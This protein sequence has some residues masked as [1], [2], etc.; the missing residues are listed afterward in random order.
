MK[1]F[2]LNF[3]KNILK[4]NVLVLGAFILLFFQGMGAYAQI[5]TTTPATRCGEGSVVLHATATSGTIKWYAEPFY[6]TALGTGDTFTTPS[7]TVT[8]TYYVDAVDGNGCSVNTDRGYLRVG[9]TATISENAI[10][11]AIFYSSSTF[12]QSSTT[13]ET[14]TLTGTS[15]GTFSV[16]PST[17]LSLTSTGSFTPSAC[18]VGTYTIT[19]T[20]PPTTGCVEEPATTTVSIVE[21]PAPPA[22]SYTGSP[23]C[24]T[25]SDKTVTQTGATGGTYSA[26]PSGLVINSTTGTIS[27]NGS[28]GGTYTVIY[29]VPGAGGCDPQTDNVSV[30]IQQR[31]TATISYNTPFTKNQGIQSV[32]LNGTGDYTG[33]TYSYTASTSGTLQL[34]PGTGAIDPGSSDAGT[35]TIYYTI[36]A[37]SPCAGVTAQTTVTIYQMATATISGETAA[38]Q[39]SSPEPEITFTGANGVAP[40]TFTYKINSGYSQT[41]STTSESSQAVV[42]QPTLVAGIY[43]YTLLSVTDN[44]GSTQLFSESNTATITVS[45]PAVATFEYTDSPYCSDGENPGPTFLNGGVAGTFSATP[46]TLIF[47]SGDGVLPGT[48]DLEASTP[49]TYTVTNT[50]A[51]AGGCDIITATAEVTITKLPLAGFSYPATIYCQ[52][53]ETPPT[54]TFDDGAVAGTFTSVPAGV[55][56]DATT[57]GKIDLA[58]STP[59]TYTILNTISASGGCSDVVARVENFQIIET[60][61]SPTIYYS[62]SPYC[63]TITEA[64]PVELTGSTGGTFTFNRTSEG[65]G[66]LSISET[67]G[68]ITP[69][70]SAPGTYRITYTVGV[71]SCTTTAGTDVTIYE[72]PVVTNNSTYAICSGENTNITL[73]AS[74]TSSF[75]WTLGEVSPNILDASA[76]SGGNIDQL[77]S[78]TSYTESGT[79]EYVVIPTSTENSCEGNSF[80]ITV[81]VNPKPQ[82]VVNDPNPVCSPGTVDLTVSSVTEGST[83]GLTLTYWTDYE[84]TSSLSNPGQVATTGTYYIKGTNASGCYT[85][86]EVNVTINPLPAAPT[87]NDITETYDGNEYTATASAE[88]GSSVVYYNSETDGTEIDAPAGTNAGTYTAWA[89]AVNDETFCKSA[90]RTLVTL[91]INKVALTITA[92][93]PSKTYGTSLIE[94][95]SETNF[96]ADATGV[97]SETVTSVTLTPDEAGLSATTSAGTAYVVTPSLATGTGGFVDSNYYITYTPYQ[98]TV[99]AKQLTISTPELTL[100]KIYDENTTAQVT[101]GTLSGVETIDNVNVGVTAEANYDTADVGSGKTITVVYSL[102]GDAR[103]NY[104]APVNHTVNTGIIYPQA[105]SAEATQIF[106]GN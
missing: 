33:G 70:A 16:D 9:V 46:E 13:E 60:P 64:Q 91:T 93:G 54:P 74:V 31:P 59:G 29:Y 88:T 32:T 36:A 72:S 73:A 28:L 67:T 75:R 8:T 17:G 22:I 97:G 96:T 7:L 58:N 11:A 76:G 104:I 14:V 53:D 23:W 79:V 26:T 95:T 27:P 71:S 105:P 102:T 68:A 18:S 19:Y 42:T 69:S 100:S 92:T 87:A 81:T 48:I 78:N 101:A 38:C 63:N 10:Q 98:G 12:C 90:S 44:N 40:Y 61:V 83:S 5:A 56:F 35:Y 80:T 82:L 94:E 84:A 41:I 50:I 43:I 85:V 1:K 51:A 55:R 65:E 45:I 15:G 99:A 25:E 37:V 6:G 21:A 24:S 2:Y 52:N 30:T 89:E 103:N 47:A 86:R 34:D 4:R 106:C 3:S 57:P 77:L 62:G 39:N 20:A 49:G 66:I